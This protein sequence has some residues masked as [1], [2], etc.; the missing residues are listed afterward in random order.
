M[1]L[2]ETLKTIDGIFY[3]I[4]ENEKEIRHNPKARSTELLKKIFK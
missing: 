3:L 1:I 2:E 4:S